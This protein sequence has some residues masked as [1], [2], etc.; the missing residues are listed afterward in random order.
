MA[1]KKKPAKKKA[2]R[3]ATTKNYARVRRQVFAI[4]DLEPAPYNARSIS[5]EALRGLTESLESFGLLAMPVVNVASDPP[6]IVGGHQRIKAMQAQGV[7]EVECIVVKLDEATERRA[8]FALNNPHIE[9]TFVPGLT[10]ALLDEIAVDSPDAEDMMKNLRLDALLKQ[11]V[12]SAKADESDRVVKGGHTDDDEVPPYATTKA[13]SELGQTYQIGEHRLHCGR[14]K[15]PYDI[16]D[17]GLKPAHMGITGIFGKKP[18]TEGALRVLLSH[19]LMNTEGAVYVATEEHHLPALVEAF[20]DAGSCT[21][22]VI[23]AHDPSIKPRSTVAFR[24]AAMPV[25]YGWRAGVAHAYYGGLEYGNV[26]KMRTKLSIGTIPVEVAVQAMQNSSVASNT[27]LDPNVTDGS[28]LIA[29]E[30]T[31]RKLIGIVPT[32]RDMDRVRKRWTAF[33]KGPKA[34]WKTVTKAI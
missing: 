16:Q 23:V 6:R 24:P 10:R 7:D 28:T 30:K 3:R 20:A 25:L 13:V 19:L 4:A 17:L 8:N 22:Q 14:L 33:A 15:E 9:G 5:Q 32:A 21:L 27:I 11:A 18:W 12:R 34:N 26:W 2:R 29:A 31:G 1:A